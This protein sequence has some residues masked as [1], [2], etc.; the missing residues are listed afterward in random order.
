MTIEDVIQHKIESLGTQG[1]DVTEVEKYQIGISI[2]RSLALQE[3]GV[4]AVWFEA[5]LQDRERRIWMI[6]IG[7][8]AEGGDTWP[9]I[10][11]SLTEED[12]AQLQTICDGR[13]VDEVVDVIELLVRN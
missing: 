10:F 12:W 5:E 13:T 8:M 1:F 2:R 6:L 7:R 9:E 11:S 4:P 3:I